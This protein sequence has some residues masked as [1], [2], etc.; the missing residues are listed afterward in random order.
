[1]PPRIGISVP[2]DPANQIPPNFTSRCAISSSTTY[3]KMTPRERHYR[4]PTDRSPSQVN[5][6]PNHHVPVVFHII[7]HTTDRFMK[8]VT[9][10]IRAITRLLW[11]I[12][13]N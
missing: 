2:D 9:R 7:S 12:L 10:H 4:D 8:H 5:S 1:M 6:C 13:A 11:N 3:P